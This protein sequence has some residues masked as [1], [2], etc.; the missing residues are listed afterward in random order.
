MTDRD[1]IQDLERRLQ[2]AEALLTTLVSAGKDVL[3]ND[4]KDSRQ[5]LL[6]AIQEVKDAP[7]RVSRLEALERL[8]AVT[9][10]FTVGEAKI[11]DLVC[12]VNAVK[13]FEEGI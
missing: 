4:S 8:Y 11:I 10:R 1:Y 7:Q 13:Q 3:A 2:S 6:D 5:T 9:W 12:A